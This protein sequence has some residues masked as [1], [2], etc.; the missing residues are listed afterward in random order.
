MFG[1]GPRYYSLLLIVWSVMRECYMVRYLFGEHVDLMGSLSKL[2]KVKSFSDKTH[3]TNSHAP[4]WVEL[5]NINIVIQSLN[6]RLVWN[7]MSLANVAKKNSAC[8]YKPL[9]QTSLLFKYALMKLANM[10]EIE[11]LYIEKKIIWSYS[12]MFK[13]DYYYIYKIIVIKYA[14]GLVWV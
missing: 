10:L 14:S 7:E 8:S 9:F 6:G 5:W 2:L 11:L 13:M 1:R 12:Y 3:F 4:L